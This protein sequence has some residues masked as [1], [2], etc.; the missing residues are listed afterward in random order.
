MCR[1]DTR[2]SIFPRV[3]RNLLACSLADP[4]INIQAL[5]NSSP[6]SRSTVT[7]AHSSQAISRRRT[8][9]GFYSPILFFSM[10]VDMTHRMFRRNRMPC[11]LPAPNYFSLPYC[12]CYCTV[13][14]LVHYLL[15]VW[16]L[17]FIDRE[18]HTL[19]SER[20]LGEPFVGR[21]RK[22]MVPENLFH[23]SNE[24]SFHRR[25]HYC[26]ALSAQLGSGTQALNESQNGKVTL[27]ML[28]EKHR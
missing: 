22:E 25:G 26:E 7:L 16:A 11:L 24:L 2:S 8:H 28:K 5:A 18:T 14:K 17:P 27:D 12:I 23:T 21:I 19:S 1:F 10:I 9:R 15:K 6:S 20:Q 3:A 4:W 13:L